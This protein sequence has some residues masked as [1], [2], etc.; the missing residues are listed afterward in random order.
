MQ[1]EKST[2]GGHWRN[3]K[4]SRYTYIGIGIW[5]YG[6]RTRVVTDFYRP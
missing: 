1:A 4:N 2:N 6:S 5:R 3:I